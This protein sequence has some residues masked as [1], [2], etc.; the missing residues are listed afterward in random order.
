MTKYLAHLSLIIL[1]SLLFQ[2]QLT[3]QT[4]LPA[5]KIAAYNLDHPH[6]TVYLHLD[7]EVYNAGDTIWFKAYVL[8]RVQLKARSISNSFFLKI[9]D[10]EGRVVHN[11]KH[12]VFDSE[13]KGQVALD[14]QM[15]S[16]LYQVICYSSWMKNEPYSELYRKAIR[17][18]EEATGREQFRI[19]LNKERYFI[20]DTI[21]GRIDFLNRY[22]SELPEIN[23][24]GAAGPKE[25]QVRF[26]LQTPSDNRFRIV[27]SQEMVKEPSLV[28]STSYR[29]FYHDTVINLPVPDDLHVGLYPEG[30]NL[31]TGF[32]NRVAFKCQSKSGMY[33][34]VKGELFCEGSGKISDFSSDHLGMGSFSFIPETGERYFVK[35]TEP[36]RVDKRYYLPDP[37]S[38]GWMLQTGTTNGSLRV[39]LT[40]TFPE[41]RQALVT[42]AIRGFLVNYIVR[43]VNGFDTFSIPTQDMPPGV[44][45]VSLF[46]A[47]GNPLAERLVHVHGEQPLQTNLEPDRES[48]LPRDRVRLKIGIKDGQ[49]KPVSGS[50]SLSV[51]DE[52]LCMSRNIDEPGIVSS[53]L[54]TPEIKGHIEDPGYYFEGDSRERRYHLDLLLMTQG[55][56][57]YRYEHILQHETGSMD[58]FRMYDVVFGQVLQYRYGRKGVPARGV[59]TVYNA[60]GSGS[61]ESEADG[62]FRYMHNYDPDLNPNVVLFAEPADGRGNM[63]FV[64]D[65]DPF[66]ERFGS[67]SAENAH[68]LHHQPYQHPEPEVDFADQYTLG[69]NNKWI[70]EVI[71]YGKSRITYE[72]LEETFLNTNTASTDILTSSPDIYGVLM[73]MGLPVRL[74]DNNIFYDGGQYNGPLN[75]FVDEIKRDYDFV[76]ILWTGDIK[77]LFVVKYPETQLF[78][79]PDRGYDT[80]AEGEVIMMDP[81]YVIISIHMKP[82]YERTGPPRRSNSLVL[83][84]LA[85]PKE[86]YKPL[87]DT[88]AKRYSQVPDLRKTIH[89]E[90][91]VELDENGEATI[92]FYN[93][94]RYTRMHCILEGVAED[95]TPVRGEAR[96]NVYT[97]R[98]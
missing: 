56:R 16:G 53:L 18:K 17:V 26:T 41:T 51:V 35:L 58:P 57:R 49:G 82:Y 9:L 21:R 73:N 65:P 96:Y 43:N 59:I 30:G 81:S 13:V 34:N 4:D 80:N 93:G 55:W 3:A 42:V 15:K 68:T 28:L 76:R 2:N 84:K 32:S 38:M 52:Q 90:P 40:H 83:P 20:G 31:V 47:E 5:R 98:E 1:I 27:V 60:G 72:F 24:R 44:G 62:R 97:V 78:E 70:E 36:A 45:V 92:T 7:R 37:L 10:K 95:G 11:S 87:Y 63:E 23:I 71:V 39:T 61:F 67:W 86:F 19:R 74:E 54:L 29:G 8:D 69:I 50:F 64:L 46:D 77:S 33:F 6:E 88:E 91:D 48:Y 66:D 75:W 94:D 22:E 79:I 89:W 25:G 14:E 12:P 85:M